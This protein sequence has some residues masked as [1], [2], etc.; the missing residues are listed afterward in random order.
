MSTFAEKSNRIGPDHLKKLFKH[1]LDIV[2]KH[3]VEDTPIFLFATAGMRLLSESRRK[4]LLRHI[5][6]YA[7]SETK[8]LISDC[9]SHVQVI[10]GEI[11][12]L[13]G[14]IAAN[15]LLGS[16]DSPE[17]HVHG[18]DHHT[19]GFL[20]MGGA[21]AQIAFAP[22]K[23]EAVRHAEDLKLLRMRTLDGAPIEYK[24]FVTTWLGFGVNEAR[25][26]YVDALMK[27]N[28]TANPKTLQDPCL[29]AGLSTNLKGDVFLPGPKLVN[30]KNPYLVGTGRFDQC[31]NQ[32]FPLLNKEAICVDAPCLLD[33]VHVPAIDFDVNHFVGISE[34]WH[35]THEIFEWGHN[36]KAYDFNTYQQRVNEFCSMDWSKI[37]LGID[38]H[39]WGSK[40]DEKTALDVCFR[41]S[42]LINVLHEGIGIPRVG[43]EKIQETDHNGTK[44]VLHNAKAKGFTSS[45]QAVDKIG[46]IE[47]S[48]T[49]G[50]MVLYASS[51]IPPKAEKFPVGF[52]SNVPGGNPADFQYGGIFDAPYANTTNI[53]DTP[54]DH[55]TEDWHD[56]LFQGQ[57]PRRIPGFL[58]F[59]LI[60]GLAFY[61]LC[62]RDRR[63]RL[64]RKLMRS[65]HSHPRKRKLFSPLILPSFLR[66]RDS[67]LGGAYERVLEDG[68]ATDQLELRQVGADG[69][70]GDNENSD[71][72]MKSWTVKSSGWATPRIVGGLGT[73]GILGG[74]SSGDHLD[75][76][77]ESKGGAIGL[78]IMR[79]PI[80]RS[81]LVGRIES[82]ERL[83]TL[84]FGEGRRSR[85]GSP[86]RTASRRVL[87]ED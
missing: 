21:S 32:T 71:G 23:T 17:E 55:N 53:H 7:R 6:S 25:K 54:S 87:A 28:R 50:K 48:W 26:R 57:S 19:Y 27:L 44:E 2:P 81:G 52:G 82:R 1:A 22:N 80:G 77:R 3:A 4:D 72:S 45:F 34:Y 36:D 63:N 39:S 33:G 16:F 58:L 64:Y 76:A 47:V 35:T 67:S 41:A 18:K 29:P 10:P 51:Q 24:V 9:D 40:V 69:D 68:V 79:D 15:Y 60:L 8:F 30:E 11:E 70:D 78:G 83:P 65:P 73:G 38:Q 31:L 66:S 46:D 62:G 43:L 14:W 12:G 42:W 37:R 5:C 13:Y 74:G 49:L 20:D 75:G 61:L 85:I 86:I 56:T 59:V 84:A